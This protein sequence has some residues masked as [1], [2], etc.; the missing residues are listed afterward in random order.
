MS[1]TSGSSGLGSARR[2]EMERRTLETVRAGDQASFKMSR[3]MAPSE[4]MF[5]W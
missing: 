1:V 2:D 3:Q 5:G 4:L